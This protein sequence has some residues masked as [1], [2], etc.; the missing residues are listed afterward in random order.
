MSEHEM[1]EKT[2][3]GRRCVGVARARAAGKALDTLAKIKE[4]LRYEAC[5]G[6]EHCGRK[7]SNDYEKCLVCTLDDLLADEGSVE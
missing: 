2:R 5:L 6:W 7:L 3:N 4:R 1:D